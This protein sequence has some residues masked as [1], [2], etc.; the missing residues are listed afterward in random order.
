MQVR[1]AGQAGYPI[2]LVASLDTVPVKCCVPLHYLKREKR[3][4]KG[5][6]FYIY[7]DVTHTH[8]CLLSAQDSHGRLQAKGHRR[9]AK[10]YTTYT[11]Y[12]TFIHFIHGWLH[13]RVCKHIHAQRGCL[14]LHE[15]PIQPATKGWGHLLPPFHSPNVQLWEEMHSWSIRS[16]PWKAPDIYGYLSDPLQSWC[17]TWEDGG[18]WRNRIVADVVASLLGDNAYLPTVSQRTVLPTGLMMFDALTYEVDF[19]LCTSTVRS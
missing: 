1:P 2:S 8:I 19:L 14:H 3:E 18:I 17:P 4:E 11:I 12:S 5:R 15:S 9:C 16:G 7:P 13:G 6:K 10:L